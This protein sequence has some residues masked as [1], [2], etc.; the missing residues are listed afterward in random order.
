MSTTDVTIIG[1]GIVG[2]AIA[3][4]CGRLGLNTVLLEQESGLGRGTTS[5]NSEVSHGGMY[6]PE[7]SLKA[8]FCVEGRHLLKAFC[9]ESGVGYRQCGKLIVAVSEDE[10][11]ELEKLQEL[12]RANGVED[13]KMLNEAELNSLE[14]E[15][16]AVAAL[17]S[18]RTAI[19]DAEGATRAYARVA[20]ENGVQI[21]TSAALESLE[22]KDGNWRVGVRPAT[23]HRR[24][25]WNHSSDFVINA[26]GLSA[27]K[28]AALA[29]VDVQSRGWILVPV[30]GNYFR[31][32]TVHEGRVSR[33]VYPVPPLDQSSLGVHL[34]L[35]LN[36]QM[37]L[38]PDVEVE[39]FDKDLVPADSLSYHVDPSRADSFFQ[40]ARRF[41]PWLDEQDLTPDMSGYRPK[42]A[43]QGFR[44]FTVKREDG[45]LDGLINL[46]GIDS[47]GLTSAAALA[48]Y[49]GCLLTDKDETRI[50]GC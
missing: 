13:L 20:S 28:V 43:T 39:A 17:H 9:R 18:P 45:L 48:E 31:I 2:C 49:V 50:S 6:Y 42:L 29:G 10:I 7:G 4:V 12:G 23:G 8:R 1:G 37:R 44:D 19:V 15:V 30:K 35:D 21:M 47:P 46:I 26:A 34:C 3:A 40:G 41:L 33:L 22:Q 27:D 14:K 11:T 32:N 24:E 5:R 25:G 16:S 38:G 36:G